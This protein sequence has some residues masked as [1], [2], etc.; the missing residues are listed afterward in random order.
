MAPNYTTEVFCFTH[1]LASL[2]QALASLLHT[3]IS[4]S[5]CM[6]YKG[7]GDMCKIERGAHAKHVRFEVICAK[8]A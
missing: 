7:E 3:I 1:Y 2:K 4:P 5:V 6:W 8:E